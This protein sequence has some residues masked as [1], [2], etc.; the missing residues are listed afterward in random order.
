MIFSKRTWLIDAFITVRRIGVRGLIALSATALILS[1]CGGG[2]AATGTSSTSGSLG[3]SGSSG[4]S[5]SSG[6]SGSTPPSLIIA[7]TPVN[8]SGQTGNAAP[9]SVSIPFTVSN[10]PSG[11]NLYAGASFSGDYVAQV[12]TSWQSA[13]AGTLTISFLAPALLGSGNYTE[14]VTLN[15]CSDS[16]CSKPISGAPVSLTVNYSVTGNALAAV[17]FYFPTTIANFATTTSVTTPETTTFLIIFNNVPP[18]GLYLTLAQPQG[19]YITN[20][21]DTVEPDTSG[22]TDVTLNI[23]LAS[24]ASLGSGYFKSSVTLQVCYDA[25]C[26]NSVVGSPITVPIS[27]EVSLTQGLEYSA[28]SS[29]VSGVSDVAYD[30][31][32]RQQ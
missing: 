4:T 29:T 6:S 20:V 12:S 9:A 25:D 10:P 3:N 27:Y 28:A 17:S 23:T 21:T 15:V 26:K 22:N 11:A 2:G 1:G 24:P 5:G 32:N 7:Q 14:T 19:G 13:A 16:A 8:V 30:T 18:A 31:A